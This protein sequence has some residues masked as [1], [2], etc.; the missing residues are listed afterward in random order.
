MTVIK[1]CGLL[2][3]DDAKTVNEVMADYAGVILS[4][5]FRRS[6]TW[7]TAAGI[8]AVLLPEIPLCGVFVNAPIEEIVPYVQDGIIRAVQLHGREDNSFIEKLRKEIGSAVI[9]KAFV[10]RSE[11]D[12]RNA[13]DSSA[14]L[15]LLDGG[16]GE[17]KGFDRTM[18]RGFDRPYLLAG[19]LNPENAAEAVRLLHPYGVDTSSGIET[20]GVKDPAKMKAFA[21]AVRREDMRL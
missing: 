2:T 10:I 6:R 7:E 5:G 14:D 1:L 11:E 9:I 13:A 15:V 8:R 19:G 16:T 12:V 17:G 4:P 3:P 21:D 20:D 18:I